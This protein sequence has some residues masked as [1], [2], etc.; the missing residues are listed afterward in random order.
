MC[1]TVN[2]GNSHD[3]YENGP[4]AGQR[5]YREIQVPCKRDKL[6]SNSRNSLVP[7]PTFQWETLATNLEEF[8]SV[9]VCTLSCLLIPFVLN[10]FNDTVF[11]CLFSS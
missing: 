8:E 5:L 6:N 11:I 2:L 9:V 3:R 10:A 7:P 1:N 4:V